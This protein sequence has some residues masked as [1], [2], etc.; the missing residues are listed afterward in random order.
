MCLQQVRTWAGIPSKYP[1]AISAWYH[2]KHRG[3]V[4]T[5]P[6]P[7]AFVFWG[8]G[9]HGHIAVSLGNWKIRTTDWPRGRV[10]TT[11]V[12][13]L[14]SRWRYRYLGWSYDLNGVTISDWT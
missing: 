11:T 9:R 5:P 3:N 8:G 2:T 6:P 13:T 12:Q 10:G 14:S 1:D 4:H 7:G